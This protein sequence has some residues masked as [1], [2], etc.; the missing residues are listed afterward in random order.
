MWLF[1]ILYLWRLLNSFIT[2]TYFQ[3][4]EF[5]QT[6]E[7]A[8]WKVF[9]HGTVTW[10]WEEGFRSYAFPFLF[11][12]VYGSICMIKSLYHFMRLDMDHWSKI[13]YK[14]G[15][16]FSKVSMSL[17]APTGECYMCLFIAD[18]L[19]HIDYEKKSITKDQKYRLKVIKIA[20]ILSMTNFL[21]R[22]F[23]LLE[24]L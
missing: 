18:F 13:E 14:V 4:D 16:Y 20:L 24:H 6:L 23:L 17:I 21:N 7:P 12:I 1:W 15:L 19:C 3:A 8:Y 9:G 11:E 22:F 2:R 5:W 10:E